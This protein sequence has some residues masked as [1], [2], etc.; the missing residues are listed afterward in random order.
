MENNMNIGN[1]CGKRIQE[2]LFKN[3]MTQYKLAKLTCLNYNTLT[4]LI[5]GRA[6]DTKTSTIFLICNELNIS[7]SEFYN[8]PLFNKNNVEI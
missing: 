4:D 5:K 1:A 2:L 6:K 7:I 3:S 8:S